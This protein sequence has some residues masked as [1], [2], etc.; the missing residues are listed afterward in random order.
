M[1]QH[2]HHSRDTMWWQAFG[3]QIQLLILDEIAAS[4]DCLRYATVSR[5]WQFAIQA[6]RFSH[7]RL[8]HQDKLDVLASQMVAH[9][10]QHVGYIWLNIEFP[11]YKCPKCEKP[12]SDRELVINTDIITHTIER[13]YDILKRWKPRAHGLTLELSMQSLADNCH[14]FPT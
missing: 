2:G 10:Q 3:P 8:S 12:E 5:Q 4:R 6:R 11:G 7:L 1:P 9:Q 14:W 13:L